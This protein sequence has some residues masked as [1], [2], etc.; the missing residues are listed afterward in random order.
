VVSKPGEDEESGEDDSKP[1]TQGGERPAGGIVGRE[2]AD[3]ASGRSRETGGRRHR[4][5]DGGRNVR[6]EESLE[7]DDRAGARRLIAVVRALVPLMIVGTLGSMAI[8]AVGAGGMFVSAVGGVDIALSIVEGIRSERPRV[9]VGILLVVLLTV[10][11]TLFLIVGFVLQMRRA[12]DERVHVRVTDAGMGVQRDGSSYWRSSG[13]DVPFDA[14]TA[15]EYVDPDETS[16]RV[17]LGDW[18]A[19]K[20]FAGRS[21]SWVRIERN[22]GP[23]V[24]VGSDRP[25]ELAETIARG[26]PGVGQAEPF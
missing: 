18:R 16:L 9:F 2:R 8:V 24:Y 6:F 4:S 17:E 20:F 12:F 7:L 22:D 10:G 19:P 25:L 23:A 1:G 5:T 11:F 14:I 26:A 21:R 13:V 15:V 3:A